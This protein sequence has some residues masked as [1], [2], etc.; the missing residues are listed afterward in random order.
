MADEKAFCRKCGA[1]IRVNDDYCSKC[2]ARQFEPTPSEDAVTKKKDKQ[3][4]I[5]S[6]NLETLIIGSLLLCLCL[7]F[8]FAFT[9][10]PNESQ[11]QSNIVPDTV[12]PT[13]STQDKNI[14]FWDW[15]GKIVSQVDNYN[16]PSGYNYAVVTVYIK[17]EANN[18]VSTNPLYWNLTAD[19]I[20]YAPDASISSDSIKHQTVD[21]G[22]GEKIETQFV[23]LVKGDPSQAILG[24]NGVSAP[25]MQRENHYTTQT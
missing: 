12:T 21:V 6:S 3:K 2:G 17:N 14:C 13:A 9:T 23:Y 5:I 19:G 7:V 22:K 24:Y 8:A 1:E 18:S 20:K 11:D 25:E 4:T 16:A 10:H 15:E